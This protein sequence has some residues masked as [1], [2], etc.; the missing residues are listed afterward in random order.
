M[1][2][3]KCKKRKKVI[4]RWIHK[5]DMEKEKGIDEKGRKQKQTN[6]NME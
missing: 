4:K 1:K 6:N 5:E 3:D 2:K